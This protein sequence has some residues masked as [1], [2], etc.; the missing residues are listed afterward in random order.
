MKLKLSD[1]AIPIS[2]A[3]APLIVVIM[4]ICSPDHSVPVGEHATIEQELEVF[5]P[6][7][8]PG[9]VGSP[10]QDLRHEYAGNYNR[11]RKAKLAK[12]TSCESCGK[13]APDLASIGA[14]LETHHVKSIDRIYSEKL[15]VSLIWDE[16][17]LIVLCRGAK[18]EECHFN[19]GHDPDGPKGPQLPTW[20]KS[21]PNVRQDARESLNSRGKR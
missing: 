18:S 19:K 9:A 7:I 16:D 8:A 5:S 2:L 10:A 17:N 14:H 15:D 3:M 20:T 6:P 21:N 1:F 11:S 12:Q 4:A 13:S